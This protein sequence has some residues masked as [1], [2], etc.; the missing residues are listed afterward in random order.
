MAI[1]CF[2][3]CQSKWSYFHGPEIIFNL[4]RPYFGT[5][6]ILVSSKTGIFWFHCQLIWTPMVSLIMEIYVIKLVEF[7]CYSQCSDEP[8]F[9]HNH[10][11][12]I[13]Q[14]LHFNSFFSLSLFKGAIDTRNLC[15][16]IKIF[17]FVYHSKM[18]A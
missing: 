11:I 13:L 16:S 10:I 15:S 4:Y 7:V 6:W 9:N 3:Q 1:L 5:P 18:I 2:R 8:C 12:K 14:H 17:P